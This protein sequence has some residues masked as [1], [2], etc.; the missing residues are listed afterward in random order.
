[1][2]FYLQ[3]LQN[4]IKYIENK[5][6]SSIDEYDNEVS[7]EDDFIVKKVILNKIAYKMYK[8]N[9][10][11]F[12]ILLIPDT[13]ELSKDNFDFVSDFDNIIK[14]KKNKDEIH[15]SLIS[16]KCNCIN[17]FNYD[18]YANDSSYSTGNYFCDI[19]FDK[20][21]ILQFEYLKSNTSVPDFL[22]NFNNRRLTDFGYRLDRIKRN[23]NITKMNKIN[24]ASLLEAYQLFDSNF[25]EI[26][27]NESSLLKI[28]EERYK[29]NTKTRI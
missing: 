17:L 12:D 7:I 21:Y 22:Y 18:F 27:D 20:N 15:L 14:Y 2:N 1:M 6:L 16:K 23:K 24:E 5:Y 29:K 11:E 10:E 8:K 4:E 9:N 3:Q 13:K 28:F 19:F 25:N 26:E